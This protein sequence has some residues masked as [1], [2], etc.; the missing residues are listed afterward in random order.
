MEQIKYQILEKCNT[1]WDKELKMSNFVVWK[2]FYRICSIIMELNQ[3]KFI[4][5]ISLKD[6]KTADYVTIIQPY[7]MP[8]ACWPVR[9]C[10][11][12]LEWGSLNVFPICKLF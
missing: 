2:T 9:A 4:V 7:S 10:S 3:Q 8:L 11:W 5:K 6:I 12:H 1:L